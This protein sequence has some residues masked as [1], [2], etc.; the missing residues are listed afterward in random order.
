MSIN[1]KHYNQEWQEK[2]LTIPYFLFLSISPSSSLITG[3]PVMKNCLLGVASLPAVIFFRAWYLFNY[4]MRRR[5]PVPYD[6]V[7]AWYSRVAELLELAS[8]YLHHCGMA[9]ISVLY[10]MIFLRTLLYQSSLQLS[11]ITQ[12]S[13]STD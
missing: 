9:S 12:S 4:L 8:I 11:H 1:Q 7:I 2:S 6:Q 5:T 10:L 3:N 13:F